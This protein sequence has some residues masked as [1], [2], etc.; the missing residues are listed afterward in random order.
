MCTLYAMTRGRAALRAAVRA[1]VDDVGNM[2]PLPGI[3]P[4]RTAPIVRRAAAGTE[5]KMARWGMPCPPQY[6][7]PPVVNVR[8][9]KSPHWRQWLGPKNRC[10]VPF[11]SFCE[12]HDTPDAA[13][14]RKVPHWF[15]LSDDRPLGFFAG[16]WCTWVGTRGTKADPVEGEHTLFAFLTT[17]PNPTVKAVH[18]KAM[19]VILTAEPDLELW[20]TAPIAE[21]IALQRPLPEGLLRVVATGQRSDGAEAA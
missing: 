2:P 19:P 13:T 8:N 1:M 5:I 7:G 11:T 20:L 12:Y 6:G 9:A 16:I 18:A 3:F 21:A 10:L 17:E 15:A 14:G 4:D